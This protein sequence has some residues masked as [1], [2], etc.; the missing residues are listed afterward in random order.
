MRCDAYVRRV[1]DDRYLLCCLWIVYLE[2]RC[3]CEPVNF[4]VAYVLHDCFLD[5]L[6]QGGTVVTSNTAAVCEVTR[7]LPIYK[8]HKYVFLE[9]RW[10]FCVEGATDFAPGGFR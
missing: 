7:Y 3:L 1:S 9:F 5:F 4:G 6:K 8:T 2:S 10:R